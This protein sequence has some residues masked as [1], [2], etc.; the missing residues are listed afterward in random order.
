MTT[1][2]T[3]RTVK[4]ANL[5]ELEVPEENVIRFREGIPGFES[6]REFAMVELENIKPFQYLQSLG[7]PPIALLVVNPFLFAAAYKFDLS[8]LQMEELEAERPEDVIVFA[9]ATIPE[10]PAEATINL[11][12]PVLINPK[13]RIGKQVVLL[14]GDYPM[15]HPLMGGGREA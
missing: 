1:S 15:R 6:A 7:A 2:S 13:Q 14:E 5:G 9:V 12:A 4:T 8:P 11:M 3:T 10:N